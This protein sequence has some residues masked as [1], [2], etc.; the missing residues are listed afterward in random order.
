MM[1]LAGATVA[2]AGAAALA[3]TAGPG[4][5][6]DE[7]RV[8]E[9]DAASADEPAPE[10]PAEGAEI[11]AEPPLPMGP[12]PAFV[13]P[14]RLPDG[15]PLELP[16]DRRWVFV[17]KSER[18]MVVNDLGYN[19]RFRVALGFAPEGA[20]EVEGDGRTPEGEFYV[21][22]RVLADRF[23]RFLGLSY[24]TPADAS[25]GA[26]AGLLQPIEVRAI[27]RAH[28]ARSRPPWNTR[29]GGNV[30]IHGWGRRRSIERLH[31]LGKDWTDGCIGVTNDEI[32]R[33]HAHV[34]LGTRVV[35]VP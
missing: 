6:S 21:C 19:E 35:I 2:L 30:G 17:D 5:P 22:Q 25:R 13:L 12:D 3:E 28:R 16:P 26:L 4:G 11:P 31:A 14:T 18:L 29:L 15:R 9:G 24:P 34:R 33:V 7:G 1:L 27:H 32:E 23:H 20:K 8:D 10:P